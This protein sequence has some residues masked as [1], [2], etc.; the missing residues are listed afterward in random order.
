MKRHSKP[1][2]QEEGEFQREEIIGL[3]RRSLRKS[4]FG[5]LQAR[6]TEL[7]RFRAL[8]D[9]SSDAIILAELPGFVVVDVNRA[10]QRLLSCSSAS[11]SGRPLELLFG[12]SEWRQIEAHLR[13]RREQP[14]GTRSPGLLTLRC[15]GKARV[16]EFSVREDAFEHRQYLVLVARD[17][18]ERVRAE[19]ALRAAKEEAEAA[20]RARAR[21]L[22]I[23][24]H[25]LRTPLTT[26][27]L[28]LQQATRRPERLQAARDGLLERMLKQAR[29]LATMA[30]D[31]L[32]VSRLEHDRLVLRKQRLDLRSLVA[33]VVSGFQ[34]RE[35]ERHLGLELPSVPVCVDAD[36]PRTEQ[37]LSNLLENALQYSPPGTPVEVR[38]TL[39]E[40]VARVSVKD[41]GPG[42]SE[43]DRER[44]F[45]PFGRLGEAGQGAPGLGLGLYLS[46]QIAELEGGELRA[47]PASGRGSTFSLYLPL[48]HEL[49]QAEVGV[50][51]LR[52]V[53]G[54]TSRRNLN[55]SATHLHHSRSSS[56]CSCCPASE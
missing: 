14:Q 5:E 49:L 18:T 35:S 47:E 51:A 33:E 56:G 9:E 44:L 55:G 10:G 37:V 41:E 23:A 2:A 29:W 8:L 26:L 30:E 40:G 21:F 48:A 27:M 22:T 32:D 31:L 15:E 25:E 16:M 50:T 46:R 19:Q 34:A 52:D 42:I 1:R 13:L 7:A 38:L 11:V 43:E 20:A 17:V 12:P 3:G 4:Y 24:S 53:E 54:P 36:P 39:R 45:K 6:L 28:L